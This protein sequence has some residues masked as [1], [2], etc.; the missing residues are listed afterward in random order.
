MTSP[1]IPPAPPSASSAPPSAATR[2]RPNVFFDWIRE[3]DIVRTRGWIG[4]VAVG[5]ANR[6]GI[7]AALIRGILVVITL[8]GFPA[9][10]L[11]AI[12]WLLLPDEHDSI[13]LQEIF[14]GRFQPQLIGILATFFFAMVPFSSLVTRAWQ[15][16]TQPAMMVAVDNLDGGITY[17]SETTYSDYA[18]NGAMSLLVPMA[19]VAVALIGAI[20]VIVIARH[21]RA[22]HADAAAASLVPEPTGAVTPDANVPEWAADTAVL[23]DEPGQVADERGPASSDEFALWREQHAQTQKDRDAFLI[24]QQ[25]DDSAAERARVE[26]AAQRGDFLKQMAARRAE[27]RASNPRASLAYN[28]GIVGAAGV[29]ACVVVL[30]RV[31][32]G[33]PAAIALG[34]FAG[35]L[36]LALGMIIAGAMRRRSG[37][38][39][40]A[41]VVAL[42]V[43]GGATVASKPTSLVWDGAGV[44]AGEMPT[45]NQPFGWLQV[46][47]NAYQENREP[48]TITKGDG[49]TMIFVDA[50]VN[51]KF[52]GTIGNDGTVRVIADSMTG[53]AQVQDVAPYS[54]GD[55]NSFAVDIRTYRSDAA[56]TTQKITLDQ[57]SGWVEIIVQPD[58]TVDGDTADAVAPDIII[59]K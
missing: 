10:L 27:R 59:K 1:N 52:E 5:I 8:L 28:L 19:A 33:L 42:V 44:F 43:G 54:S 57:A 45:V 34:A 6:T 55:V 39:A 47:A 24:A 13:P 26:K 56:S 11:Y 2:P 21:R 49:Y 25:T 58:W 3:A 31:A 37:F 9:I 18:F 17:Y 16:L 20:T 48:L 36:V 4:G 23:V 53:D 41:T 35:A 30:W 22:A 7:D 51:L 12:L 50:G 29:A 32:D 40:L 46:Y 14:R 38:L 15:A